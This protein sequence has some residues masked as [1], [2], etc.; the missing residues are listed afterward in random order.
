MNHRLLR[1]CDLAFSRGRE[2]D[3]H[4]A[5]LVGIDGPNATVEGSVLLDQCAKCS[6]VLRRILVLEV[7]VRLLATVHEL[8]DGGENCNTLDTRGLRCL[9]DCLSNQQIL[10]GDDVLRHAIHLAFR[11]SM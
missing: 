4:R 7:L 11:Y 9:L 1:V 6:G 8:D 10:S 5:E 2:V 3:Q